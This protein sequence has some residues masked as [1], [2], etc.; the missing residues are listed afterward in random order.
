MYLIWISELNQKEIVII[1]VEEKKNIRM[2]A[3][4]GHKAP[5][6]TVKCQF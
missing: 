2:A 5:A 4:I 6:K 1:P 3:I